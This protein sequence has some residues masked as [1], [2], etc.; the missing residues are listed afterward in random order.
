MLPQIFRPDGTLTEFR[1]IVLQTC[2]SHGAFGEYHI[3]IAQVEN[4]GLIIV[5]AI[6]NFWI[7]GLKFGLPNKKNRQAGSSGFIAHYLTDV[8][9]NGLGKGI[10]SD[11]FE[12]PDVSGIF[13]EVIHFI[14]ID[15]E[16]MHL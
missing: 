14:F 8:Q 15:S 13:D 4:M 9:V 10:A 6:L 12:S 2:R 7:C 11:S 3:L 1:R 5:S 16:E